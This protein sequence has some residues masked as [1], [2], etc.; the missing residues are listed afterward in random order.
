MKPNSFV[1]LHLFPR[2]RPSARGSSQILRVIRT[3]SPA[4]AMWFLSRL[5]RLASGAGICSGS[6]R[7]RQ[8]ARFEV[9]RLSSP[10]VGQPSKSSQVS[11]TKSLPCPSLLSSET[12]TSAREPE[13][14]THWPTLRQR[15]R[16][17]PLASVQKCERC[18]LPALWCTDTERVCISPS[19]DPHGSGFATLDKFFQRQGR[20]RKNCQ[21]TPRPRQ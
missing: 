19:C 11:S 8:T 3:I 6:I 1:W 7:N 9:R 13:H 21:P 16:R 20:G 10:T 5:R 17:W 2:H 12:Q 4:A 15:L 14:G 18:Q